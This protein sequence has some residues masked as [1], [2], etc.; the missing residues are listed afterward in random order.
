MGV[1][2]YPEVAFPPGMV[3]PYAGSTAPAGWL[4][5]NGQSLLRSDYPALFAVIGTTY[6]LGTDTT[7]NTTFALPNLKGRVIVGMNAA[8]TEFDALGETGGSKTS[9]AAHTH[10]LSNHGHA[11][12]AAGPSDNVTNL[13]NWKETAGHWPND[14][15]TDNNGQNHDHA[16]NHWHLASIGATHWNGTQT[17]GHH[18]RPNVASEAPWEGANWAGGAPVNVDGTA[19]AGPN[20]TNLSGNQRA[21]HNHGMKNHWHTIPNHDHAMKSHT[22]ANT[23]GN[24]TTNTSGASSAAAAS[25]NLPP[26]LTLNYLIKV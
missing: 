22:H 26:Y 3:M 8:E 16:I 19:Q 13:I 14:N 9:T 24:P 12:T 20:G 4:V 11:H 1:T 17:H 21:N 5:C 6:G 7:T 23:I 10:D 18:D 2:L 15:T 25:G